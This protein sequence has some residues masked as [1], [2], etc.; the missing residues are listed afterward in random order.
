MPKLF[1]IDIAKEL[2]DGMKAAGG[3]RPLVLTKY[4]E[5]TR[6][7]GALTAG[8]NPTSTTHKASGFVEDT[9]SGAGTR[10]GTLT[11]VQIRTVSILG[12]SI[13]G[14]VHPEA[15]DVVTFTDADAGTYKLGQC[16]TDPVD[17][18][19]ICEVAK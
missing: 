14:G 8:T 15:N 3:L 6:T 7:T 10:E 5:G 4:A 16:G 13:E 9:S 12:D 19:F 11:K 17:A 2:N 18:L 1:G